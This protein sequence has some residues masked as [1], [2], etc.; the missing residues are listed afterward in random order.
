MAPLSPLVLAS[1]SPRRAELLHSAGQQFTVCPVDCDETW[2]P[3]ET[4]LAYVE[5]VAAAKA[6]AACALDEIRR[7]MIEGGPP[8][9]ILTADTTVWL[10][11]NSEPLAKPRDHAHAT[12][13]LRALTRGRA[14]QVSTACAFMR[15]AA[16]PGA[17][18]QR[19]ARITQT[20]LV[21]MRALSDPQFAAW[22]GPYLELARWQDKAGG[23]A[24]QG[25]AAALVESIEG[26]YT[27]VVGLPLAQVLTQLEALHV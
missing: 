12:A 5:R 3:G 10:E 18:P 16:Q 20:T 8:P 24:I 17:A 23:Y 19:L 27:N 6:V 22:I 14:H 9:V 1:A 15:P 2:H 7:S 21:R 26:S 25:R 4:P 13:M 11:A